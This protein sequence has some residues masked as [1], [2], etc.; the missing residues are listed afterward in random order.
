ML[1]AGEVLVFERD[2][3]SH[4]DGDSHFL[5]RIHPTS[6]ERYWRLHDEL[7]DDTWR[8]VFERVTDHTA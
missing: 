2:F 8:Q 7:P 4:Y 6:E 3:Y 1:R 5:F